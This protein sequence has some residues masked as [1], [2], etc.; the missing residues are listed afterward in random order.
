MSNIKT[1]EQKAA[2]L[3]FAMARLRAANLFDKPAAAEQAAEAAA[4][5]LTALSEIEIQRQIGGA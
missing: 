5:L 3:R 1:L 2:A 4:D